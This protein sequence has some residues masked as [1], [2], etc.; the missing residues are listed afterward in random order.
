MVN[1]RTFVDALFFI[2]H[3]LFKPE[4]VQLFLSKYISLPYSMARH[5]DYTGL[6]EFVVN[7]KKLVMKSYGTPIE[8]TVLWRGVFNGREGGELKLWS[9]LIL[10][11]DVVLDVGANNGLFALVASTNDK[12]VVYAFEPVSS[13]YE[14][15]VEN[16]SLSSASNVTPLKEIVSDTIGDKT[17]YVPQKGWVDVASVNESFAKQ[18]LGGNLMVEEICQSQTLDAFIEVQKI[19]VDKKIVCKIDVE[20]AEDL[21]LQGMRSILKTHK[22]VFMAEL[23]D[24]E[25]FNKVKRLIPAEYKIFAILPKKIVLT[26][27]HLPGAH[28]YLFIKTE[29]PEMLN[30]LAL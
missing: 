1:L 26:D 30:H 7:G 23:L 13:V 12:A 14:M 27:S 29:T 16:I 3:P 10:D 5:L 4:L 24:G 25:Y 8:I 6:V 19:G 20:G 15:L 21:V 18:R 2:I 28:N 11:A 9:K 17:I 22:V